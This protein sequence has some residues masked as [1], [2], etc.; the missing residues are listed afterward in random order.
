MTDAEQLLT[1]KYTIQ[2]LSQIG[3]WEVCR[4]DCY[5]APY[6]YVTRDEAL[7]AAKTIA[8]MHIK[9]LAE[10]RTPTLRIQ[11]MTQEEIDNLPKW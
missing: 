2:V 10:G 6:T 1:A 8:P 4:P 5:A 3:I 7:E 11:R 9:S